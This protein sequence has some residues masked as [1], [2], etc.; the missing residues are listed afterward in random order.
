MADSGAGVGGWFVETATFQ[1]TATAS[2]ALATTLKLALPDAPPTSVVWTVPSVW[3]TPDID[4]S[5]APF[6]SPVKESEIVPARGWPLSFTYL[7]TSSLLAPLLRRTLRS[8]TMTSWRCSPCAGG[9]VPPSGAGASA[10]A[11]H[12]ASSSAARDASASGLWV[13]VIG[14]PLVKRPWRAASAD[15]GPSETSCV[16]CLHSNGLT[17]PRPPGGHSRGQMAGGV[18]CS[19]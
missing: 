17:R 14:C 1:L 11:A 4:D 7:T 9:G 8:P 16:I 15:G 18:S 6:G 2:G 12:P 13:L 19:R 3:V 5:V 10:S